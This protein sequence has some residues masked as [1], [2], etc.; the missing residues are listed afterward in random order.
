LFSSWPPVTFHLNL[1]LKWYS[2]FASDVTDFSLA[3]NKVSF[4]L[5]EA[6]H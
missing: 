5:F 2:I 1:W 6:S 4:Q 3:N